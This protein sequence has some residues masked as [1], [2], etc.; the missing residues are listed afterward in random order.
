MSGERWKLQRYGP[1][2]APLAL[3]SYGRLGPRSL[4]AMEQAARE[5]ALYGTAAT[6]PGV[7]LR[8]WRQG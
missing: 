2:A 6:S 4:E 5:A 3:E 8:R 1:G 7:L